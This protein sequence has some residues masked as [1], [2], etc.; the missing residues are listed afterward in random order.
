MS[1]SSDVRSV[2][3]IVKNELVAFVFTG[4]DEAFFVDVKESY[5][6]KKTALE[7]SLAASEKKLAVA[8]RHTLAFLHNKN[9]LHDLTTIV[10]EA[11]NKEKSS[12]EQCSFPLR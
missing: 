11:E 6:R 7:K 3:E 12:K 10:D 8:E 5:A 4:D 9:T 1:A 2:H